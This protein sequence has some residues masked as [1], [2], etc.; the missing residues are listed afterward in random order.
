L[1]P[2]R[3]Q[4]LGRIPLRRLSRRFL[5]GYAREHPIDLERL[6]FAEAYRCVL[7]LV[8]VIERRLAR[9]AAGDAAPNPYDCPAGEAALTA[10]LRDVTS[11]RVRLPRACG[12]AR[13]G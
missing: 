12:W 2:G 10:R 4:A 8:S 7:T 13:D 3:L 9:A 11:L 1:L 5:A 6:H